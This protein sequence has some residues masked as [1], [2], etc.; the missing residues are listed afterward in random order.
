MA[1]PVFGGLDADHGD[2]DCDRSDLGGSARADGTEHR[3]TAGRCTRGPGAGLSRGCS[4]RATAAAEH[5]IEVRED[6]LLVSHH[7]HER[8]PNRW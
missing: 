7:R 5:T 4:T 8:E 3:P 6:R 1:C 2:H